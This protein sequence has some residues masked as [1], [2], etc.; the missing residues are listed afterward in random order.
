MMLMI[1]KYLKSKMQIEEFLDENFFS[2]EIF[3]EMLDEIV[4]LVMT[5]S[6]FINKMQVEIRRYVNYELVKS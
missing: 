5:K 2:F 3:F 6:F 1:Q 4:M